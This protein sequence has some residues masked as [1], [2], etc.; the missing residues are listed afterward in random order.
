MQL[1]EH[2]HLDEFVRPEDGPVPPM[3]LANLKKLAARLEEV[4]KHLGHKRIHVTSGYR[5]PAH[6]QAV[7]GA[8]KSKHLTGEAADVIVEDMTA[9][10]VQQ[11][12]ETFWTG[13]MGYGRH[14]THL[15]IRPY[16]ARWNY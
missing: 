14:F 10:Q 13:G 11:Q 3:V 15:D 9:R 16:K 8:Q 6:N 2:F 4:R 5:T 1:S 7:G 12:L